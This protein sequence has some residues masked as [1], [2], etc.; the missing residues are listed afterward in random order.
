MSKSTG[1]L[2]RPRKA[3][4]SRVDNYCARRAALS[5]CCEPP[6]SAAIW[7]GREADFNKSF[8]ELANVVGNCLNRTIK[9]IGR[10][11]D[12]I[13]PGRRRKRFDRRRI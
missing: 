6:R 7:I 11:R 10:Y 13:L 5:I 4:R 9:M 12:G 1:Q 2:H 3:P 8:N